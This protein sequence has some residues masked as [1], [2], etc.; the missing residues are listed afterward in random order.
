MS[1]P[2]YGVVDPFLELKLF[3]RRL[4]SADRKR[5]NDALEAV[6]DQPRRP[7]G[8]SFKKI[9]SITY[10]VEVELS[11]E[12]IAVTYEIWP[13]VQEIRVIDVRDV[14]ELRAL[15]KWAAGIFTDIVPRKDK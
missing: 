15:L 1:N 3:L 7:D 8:Y 5:V 13:L 12:Y 11:R 2:D 10:K 6:Q 9:D 4:S 14:S